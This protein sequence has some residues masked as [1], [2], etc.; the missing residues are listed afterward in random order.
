[1]SE[2]IE[3]LYFATLHACLAHLSCTQQYDIVKHINANV[4][5]YALCD[6]HIVA[7]QM[8]EMRSQLRRRR[9]PT[10]IL[11]FDGTSDNRL[12]CVDDKLSFTKCTEGWLPAALQ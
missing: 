5:V 7:R 8:C 4:I 6:F 10:E 11:A 2:F 12:H 1:M 3:L 9:R